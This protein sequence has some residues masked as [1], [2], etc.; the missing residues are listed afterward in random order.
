[1]NFLAHIYLSGGDP[2]L[3]IGNFIADSVRGGDYS[4]FPPRIADGIWLHRRIDTYTDSHPIVKRSKDL[5]RSEYKHYS[6]VIVD[7]YYDHFLA[8]Q[9]QRYHDTPLGVYTRNFYDLLGDHRS[10]L[11]E[12][13][14]QFLPRMIEQDWL[15]NYSTLEGITTIFNQ[16][17]RR[18]GGRGRMNFAPVD[19]V[20]YYDRLE[21]DFH[22]FM[23]ELI[24]YV[25]EI[26]P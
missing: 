11:P 23:V 22:G 7:I 15:T 3:S 10:I 20:H 12:R 9:W 13:I 8:A 25:K 2:E 17:N 24:A 16:M 6:S 21:L 19:L 4:Y 1:M 5:I 26:T 18:T 14:Q